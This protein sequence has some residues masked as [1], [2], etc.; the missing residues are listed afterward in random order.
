LVKPGGD[1]VRSSVTR[2]RLW[3]SLAL[4]GAVASVACHGKAGSA[5]RYP[6]G[7]HIDM[8]LAALGPPY[9]DRPFADFPEDLCP[10]QT[11]RVVTYTGP[12]VPFL[13]HGAVAD[14]CV[15]KSNRV[16]KI[17]FSDS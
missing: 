4:V 14:L 12:R 5:A 2:F 13:I 3:A 8:V 16:I 10:P 11:T 6:V 7:T 17:L 1:G 15:D 9:S